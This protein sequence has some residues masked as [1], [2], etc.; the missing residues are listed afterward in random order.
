MNLWA[1]W[2]FVAANLPDFSPLCARAH[3]Q[4]PPPSPS[5]TYRKVSEC[6]RGA[7]IASSCEP[8]REGA[9]ERQ[10]KPVSDVEQKWG[11][12]GHRQPRARTQPGGGLCE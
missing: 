6:P 4:P 7:Q 12:E 9:A 8:V 10:A 5:V 3:R 1:A 2:F 11:L